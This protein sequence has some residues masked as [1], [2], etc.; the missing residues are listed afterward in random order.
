MS[1]NS[2]NIKKW[3]L[4]LTG[5]S[6]LHV[7]QSIGK[8]FS[9]DEVKGYYNDLT[10]KVIREPQLLESEGLPKSKTEKGELVEFPTAIFQY[11]LG[12]YDLFLQSGEEK[13]L[14][15]FKQC[16]EWA[17]DKQLKN[18]AWNGF[19]YIY[20]DHPF[21]AMTQGEGCSLLVRAYM[22]FKESKYILAAEKALSF[23]LIDVS[24]GG[25]SQYA[26]EDLVLMEYTNRPPVLNGWIFALW[27]IFDYLKVRKNKQFEEAYIKATSTL[28]RM[29]KKFTYPFWSKYDN[30]KMIASPFYH[31]LHIAQMQA[32]Y[33]ITKND[34]FQKYAEIWERQERNGCY[35]ALAFII[36]VFQ[37]VLEKE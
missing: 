19:S 1:I 2:Y 29:M 10:E 17:L 32:M 3:W 15:K 31:H 25:V 26:S 23:M 22:T 28:I 37:K 5:H 16:S 11:G 24:N 27:G 21:C 12:S 35:R 36:K 8:L 34:C 14:R 33:A 18:G 7:N 6:I 9:I 13:F 4:M 30:G 20:P